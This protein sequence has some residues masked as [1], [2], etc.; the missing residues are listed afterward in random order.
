MPSEATAVTQEEEFIYAQ[1]AT[2]RNVEQ[3]GEIEASESNKCSVG[4]K[5]RND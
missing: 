5:H 4:R 3:I 2:V 1:I